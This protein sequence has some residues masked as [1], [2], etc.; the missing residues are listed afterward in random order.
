MSEKSKMKCWDG[1]SGIYYNEHLDEMLILEYHSECYNW[2]F[3]K[4]VGKFYY[5]TRANEKGYYP[6]THSPVALTYKQGSELLYL[7]EL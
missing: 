4:K 2:K 3:H 5:L 7:G 1:P 6:K